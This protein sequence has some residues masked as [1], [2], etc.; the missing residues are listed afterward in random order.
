MS[1]R[2]RRRVLNEEE[3]ALWQH[4]VRSVAPLR[5]APRP[6]APPPAP[7]AAPIAAPVPEPAVSEPAAPMP[8]APAAKARVLKPT[9]S[10]AARRALE[11]PV[12]PPLSVLDPKVRRRLTRGGEVDARLDLHGLTQ[13]AAHRQLLLFVAQAQAAGHALV[14]VITGKGDPETVFMTGTPER[15]ILRRAVPQWLCDATMRPYVVGF[16][17]AARRHGG[18]GALYVRIRRRRGTRAPQP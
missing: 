4:V 18:D 5:A 8:K 9:G 6:L 14:L 10:T 1:R 17:S 3:R 16:E 15:G 11:A 12:P 2:G 7:I 13:A